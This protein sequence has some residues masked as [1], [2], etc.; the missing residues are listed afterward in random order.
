MK[1]W[2][3]LDVEQTRSALGQ[4]PPTAGPNKLEDTQ[5]SRWY[6]MLA[7]QFKSLLVLTLI[8]AAVLSFM[9]GDKVDALAIMTIVVLNA[10]LGFAQEWKAETALKNLKKI[11]SPRCRVLRDG[12]EVEIDAETLVPGDHVLLRAGNI[13]PADLRL[14]SVMNLYIDESALTGESVAVAKDA[15]VLP[16]NAPL[17]DRRNM[18]FMGTHAVNGHGEG[19][20]VAI[21]TAT[22]FGKIAKLTGDIRE[23]QTHLQRQLAWLAR[24]LSMAALAIAGA[25]FII[26]YLYGRDPLQMAMTGISLAVAAIPEGL[27]A[28]VTIT[29]AIGMGAM[30]RKKALLRHLQAAETLGAVSVI[31]TDKTGTLTEN[32]MTV[33]KVW[34]PDA[35]FTVSGAGYD[36]VGGFIRDGH[37][38]DPRSC[39]ELMA[40]L[41]TG[42]RCNQAR[43]EN[44]GGPWRALGSPTEAAL[45]V[46]AEKAGLRQA[47]HARIVA[48]CSFNSVRKRMTMVED[49]EGVLIAHIKGAP[50]AV[51]P[52]C[53]D[54]M[55]EGQSRK[56]DAAMRER[57]TEAYTGFA[58]QG[59]RTLLLARKIVPPGTALTAGDIEGDLVFL[60]IVGVIDPPRD[61]VREALVK[62]RSAGIRI[63]LITGDSA[64]TAQAISRQVG[65]EVNL[66]VIGTEL[67]NMSDEMLAEVLTQD[68]L[69][70]RTVPEHKFRIVKALQQKNQLVAMTGDGVNDAPALKQA[71]IGIA[72][73]IRGTDVAK[74]AADIVLTDDNF[75]TIIAAIEEGRRQYTN[76]RKFV[77]FLVAHNI[78]EV[79]AVFLNI[80]WGGPLILLPIQILWINLA[81]D[82]VTALALSTEKAEKDIMSEPPRIIGQPL[83]SRAGMIM[84]AGFGLYI[85]LITLA[86]YHV[87]LGQS[88]ALANSVAF[89]AIVMTAQILVLNFR[90]LHG[91]VSAIGWF[92]NPW[93]LLAM[94]AMT[95]MQ[96]AALYV[97]FLQE[98]LH[99]VPLSADE[100]GIIVLAILPIFLVPEFYKLLRRSQV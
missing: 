86:L 26:G 3:S 70:A 75:A 82:S 18:A 62:A 39:P 24:Q 46:A 63:I 97:P 45:I 21:A 5:F 6:V 98:I 84:L 52:L 79:T 23:T 22:E 65:L 44:D 100:W 72:M 95:A 99:T 59:L 69:F 78:G 48:E 51:L 34:L 33:Q 38:V 57:I 11:L 67:D 90:H 19:L 81:T 71:D 37:E 30:A 80:L 58:R 20:V 68:V 61:E 32:E 73:G 7:E 12:K 13:V 94:V 16:E 14:T 60:G 17:S 93:L 35:A 40:L 25:V 77:N 15:A 9:I 29:L 50:E 89:T 47:D 83:I 87:Y 91:P 36:P 49:K 53:T 76:I 92:S 55:S 96:L 1:S 10:F 42:R 43:I 74:G 2:H 56:M 8:M 54:Y 4:L 27:P 31:C 88:Y 85:G 41:D 66:T 28:V 64:D